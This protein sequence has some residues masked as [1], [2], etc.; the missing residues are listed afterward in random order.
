MKQRWIDICGLYTNI[1]ASGEKNLADRKDF[2]SEIPVE[3]Q[4]GLVRYKDDVVPP[5]SVAREALIQNH[6]VGIVDTEGKLLYVEV[7]SFKVDNSALELTKALAEAARKYA[8]K[9][10]PPAEPEKKTGDGDKIP[11]AGEK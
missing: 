5:D 10:A 4:V 2:L 8:P 7:Q 9:A 11:P 3:F 1:Q 6:G